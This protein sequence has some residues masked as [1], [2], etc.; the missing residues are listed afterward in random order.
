M[1]SFMRMLQVAHDEEAS[2]PALPEDTN[3]SL[4]EQVASVC[5]QLAAL[6]ESHTTMGRMILELAA[7]LKASTEAFTRVSRQLELVGAYM[8]KQACLKFPLQ[9]M[10]D[11]TTLQEVVKD[12]EKRMNLV[13]IFRNLT[14]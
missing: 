5:R 10:S 1:G 4:C 9:T 8:G 6:T 13:I 2:R 14:I 7:N 11:L 12:D 3:V